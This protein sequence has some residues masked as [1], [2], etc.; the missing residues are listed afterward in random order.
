MLE[1]VRTYVRRF[2]LD[3]PVEPKLPTPAPKPTDGEMRIWL[4]QGGREH[5]NVRD[6]FAKTGIGVIAD[7]R[8]GTTGQS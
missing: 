7:E 6:E 1:D 3:E 5:Q 4:E 8:R 2:A